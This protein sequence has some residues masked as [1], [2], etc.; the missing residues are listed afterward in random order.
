MNNCEVMD[1]DDG[2]DGDNVD[3]PICGETECL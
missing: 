1:G 3:V 2:D